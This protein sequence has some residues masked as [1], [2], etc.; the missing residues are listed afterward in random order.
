MLQDNQ[1]V[2]RLMRRNEWLQA[3][4]C[5]AMA[6]AR[7]WCED[8]CST[9]DR[10]TSGRFSSCA[11]PDT[12]RTGAFW[13][14]GGAWQVLWSPSRMAVDFALQWTFGW[15]PRWLV[16]WSSVAL[17][18]VA[19]AML[20][21]V[22]A[23]PKAFQS[24]AVVARTTQISR[25]C[26]YAW[27]CLRSCARLAVEATVIGEA[28]WSYVRLCSLY[29]AIA[30]IRI[31]GTD[32]LSGMTVN[33]LIEFD[34]FSLVV[35]SSMRRRSGRAHDDVSAREET[36]RMGGSRGRAP[37]AASEHSVP[38]RP[39]MA[40]DGSS[41]QP[42]DDSAHRARWPSSECRR[43][44]WL[45]A[46]AQHGGRTA[47]AGGR[48]GPLKRSSEVEDSDWRSRAGMTTKTHAHAKVHPLST[49]QPDSN[50]PA[51][52][53][54][55]LDVVAPSPPTPTDSV[56]PSSDKEVSDASATS[57]V[58]K[59]RARR[60]GAVSTKT[61]V[62]VTERARAEVEADSGAADALAIVTASSSGA[63]GDDIDFTGAEA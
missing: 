39:G 36:S 9:S 32:L 42:F 8:A 20:I 34:A 43:P 23:R 53:P 38:G 33:Q 47:K 25:G 12:R 54:A 40:S 56:P 45:D 60:Q 3:Q 37:D 48:G 58:S 17:D 31:V 19:T 44:S 5:L 51:V 46:T 13:S 30:A 6:T 14:H 2:S 18:A 29:T 57:A 61:W 21:V 62:P 59:R 41:L 24:K 26:R 15:G 22:I 63:V 50:F 4:D 35:R 28:T 49:V 7:G 55:S 52:P 11:G 10:R 1:I 27:T 16:W